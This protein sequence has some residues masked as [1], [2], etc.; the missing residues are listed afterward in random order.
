[1]IWGSKYPSTTSLALAF[2]VLF[3][4]E[5]SL[6]DSSIGF[7]VKTHLHLRT[8]SGAN[9][10]RSIFW[11]VPVFNQLDTSASLATWN[12]ARS[13]AVSSVSLTS[14]RCRLAADT[15]NDISSGS[16]ES[17]HAWMS[18]SLTRT[19]HRHVMPSSGVSSAFESTS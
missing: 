8:C 1:M 7:Q 9:W 17:R 2:R 3:G 16:G 6:S 5:G 4:F 19:S 10:L 15:K 11:T 12:S 13:D 14:A 18:A